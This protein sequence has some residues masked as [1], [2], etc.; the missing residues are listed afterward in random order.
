MKGSVIVIKKIISLVLVALLVM[1]LVGCGGNTVKLTKASNGVEIPPYKNLTV[2]QTEYVVSEEFLDYQLREITK[3]YSSLEKVT[4]GV[5]KEKDMISITYSNYVGEQILTEGSPE[6]II[7][8]LGE[9]KFVDAFEKALVGLTVGEEFEFA[10]E[11]PVGSTY[12]ILD[13]KTVIHRGTVNY[14]AKIVYPEIT[15]EFIQTHVK[16]SVSVQEAACKTVA[17]YRDYLKDRYSFVYTRAAREA[18]IHD[19]LDVLM[20]D[21]IFPEISKEQLDEYEN[22]QFEYYKEYCSN[23]GFSMETYLKSQNITEE[24]FRASLRK[25]GE[26]II[27]QTML[28][29]AIKELESIEL[30]ENKY[31]EYLKYLTK[32]YQFDNIDTLKTYIDEIGAEELV[33]SDAEYEAIYDFLIENQKITIEKVDMLEKAKAGELE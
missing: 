21:A 4:N 7:F 33:R 31:Q 26:L 32:Y 1:S 22:G 28:L 17:D 19:I 14:I 3:Q 9:G 18:L 13:G 2:T 12:S 24:E 8:T 15:D 20:K 10:I 16:N 30:T 25:D 11:Y 29:Q 27:K 6:D 5:V 23:N